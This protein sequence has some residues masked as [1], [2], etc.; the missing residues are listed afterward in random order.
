MIFNNQAHWV[1]D[2]GAPIAKPPRWA[3]ESQA[4]EAAGRWLSLMLRHKGCQYSARKR[5]IPCD[6]GGWSKI[7]DIIEQSTFYHGVPMGLPW[8]LAIAAE[9]RKS[10]CQ[11]AM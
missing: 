9:D 11:A 5:A 6:S 4:W 8:L 10:R 2:Y 1:D 3:W 7:A